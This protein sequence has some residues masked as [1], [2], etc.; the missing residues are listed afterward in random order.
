MKNT[1]LTVFLFFFLIMCALVKEQR[2][3]VGSQYSFRN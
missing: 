2:V 3:A 1:P